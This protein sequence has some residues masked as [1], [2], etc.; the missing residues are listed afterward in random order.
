M[1]EPKRYKPECSNVGGEKKPHR[2]RRQRPV[3]CE[4]EAFPWASRTT[5]HISVTWSEYCTASK[6]VKIQ[7]LKL[8]FKLFSDPNHQFSYFYLL[9]A[10]CY[11]EESSSHWQHSQFPDLG[12]VFLPSCFLLL[13][14]IKE[15]WIL[16]LLEGKTSVVELREWNTQCYLLL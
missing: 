2:G 10:T 16:V 4:R 15:W 9:P 3:H 13:G 7:S 5:L 1:G 8:D 12:D 11:K 6:M 14:A